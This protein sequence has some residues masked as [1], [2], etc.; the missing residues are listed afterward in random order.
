MKIFPHFSI[1]L[2][3][4]AIISAPLRAETKSWSPLGLAIYP[5]MQFPSNNSSDIY[6][7]SLSLLGEE[8]NNI[9]GINLGGGAKADNIFG[10]GIGLLFLAEKKFEGIQIGFLGN[11]NSHFN[12]VMISGLFLNFGGGY[13][14]SHGLQIAGFCNVLSS[15][16]TIEGVDETL[17]GGQIALCGN[18]ADHINGFQMALFGNGAYGIKGVQFT[19]GYN[20]ALDCYGLQIGAVNNVETLYGMQLGAVNFAGELHGLQIG[21][22]NI[23]ESGRGVQIGLVNAFGRA[24]E[25]RL[26]LPLVNWRF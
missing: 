18:L 8:R 16:R 20:F 6:G 7:L 15:L 19:T 11:G 1:V 13:P 26:I 12:G 3:F 21:V 5:N 9:Y 22:V 14:T 4:I 23:A 25:D 2:L 24:G 10:I 17:V